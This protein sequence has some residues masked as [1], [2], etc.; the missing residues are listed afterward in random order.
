[1]E[2]HDFGALVGNVAEEVQQPMKE[3]LLRNKEADLFRSHL[4]SR[5][6]LKETADQV[7]QAEQAKENAAA[8]HLASF[9]MDCLSRPEVEGVHYSDLFEQYLP[10]KD[11][12]RR[13]LNDWLPEFFIKTPGGTWRMPPKDE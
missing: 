6:Y 7:D 5:W 2:A 8:A 3:D 9:I 11:K 1:M 12:P 4:Q 13:L 10:V